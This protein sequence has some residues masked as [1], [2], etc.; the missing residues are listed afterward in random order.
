MSNGTKLTSWLGW[1]KGK[2]QKAS[3]VS[4]AERQEV[5]RY[6]QLIVSS[7][8]GAKERSRRA[9]VVKATRVPTNSAPMLWWVMVKGST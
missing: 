4:S 5:V 1:A 9:K 6:V 7:Y 2:R 3:A 8:L